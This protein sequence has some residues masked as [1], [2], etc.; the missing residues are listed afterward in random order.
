MDHETTHGIISSKSAQWFCILRQREPRQRKKKLSELKTI[1][2]V[3][4]RFLEWK[5]KYRNMIEEKITSTISHYATCADGDSNAVKAALIDGQIL[6]VD[7]ILK[8]DMLF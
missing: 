3:M 8:M 5:G 4:C 6:A 2:N 1:R 7:T